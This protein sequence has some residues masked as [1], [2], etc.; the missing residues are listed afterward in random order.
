[1]KIKV[2]FA[3]RKLSMGLISLS[4]VS[5]LSSKYGSYVKADIIKNTITDKNVV[6][7]NI[8]IGRKNSISFYVTGNVNKLVLF[9]EN[10]KE[11]GSDISGT[12]FFIN[13]RSQPK[14]NSQLTVKAYN[15]I[16]EYQG[17]TSFIYTN[18][19]KLYD[20]L[21]SGYLKNTG[22]YINSTKGDQVAY[23]NAYANAIKVTNSWTCSQ[24]E[25]DSATQKY[26]IAR[27]KIQSAKIGTEIKDSSI[28]DNIDV[29]N[30]GVWFLI[31][32][33]GMTVVK[34]FNQGEELDNLESSYQYVLKFNSKLVPN[35]TLTIKAYDL[36]GSQI[37][38]LV[39][40]YTDRNKFKKE[41]SF[42]NLKGT[43]TYKLAKS[44][45]QKAYDNAFN[46]ASKVNS[47][48]NATQSQVDDVTNELNKARLD[49][50]NDT[51]DSN[52]NLEINSI[53]NISFE[54]NRIF[55]TANRNR[56]ITITD[57]E[58]NEPGSDKSGFQFYVILNKIIRPDTPLY[59]N[60]LDELKNRIQRIK[61]I[62]TDRTEFHKAYYLGN[63]KN[64][65][66]YKN[67]TKR[68]QQ[69]YDEAY[70][71]AKRLEKNYV[72]SQELVDNVTKELRN[73]FKGL[74][75]NCE[76]NSNNSDTNL[77]INNI[78]LYMLPSDKSNKLSESKEVHISKVVYA[79]VISNKRNIKI[80]LVNAEG[81]VTNKFINTDS[82]WKVFAQKEINGHL[83]YRLGTQNQ[84]ALADYFVNN[85]EEKMSG[86]ARINYVP[87]YG[88]NL[89][90]NYGKDAKWNGTR[91]KHGT[92]WKIFK[93]VNVNGKTWYNLGGNQWILGK[94]VVLE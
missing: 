22:K 29:S 43:Q 26:I 88:I 63:L 6:F 47:N 70:A 56:Y 76:N 31:P 33:K 4:I 46:K 37:G 52:K 89:W 71:D 62:Y 93:R 64:T 45:L 21:E 35:T 78:P 7:E 68:A 65:Y 2:G 60:S 17:K 40:N 5:T 44:N 82:K 32:K 61:V 72:A 91:L 59:I 27:N 86:I 50:I 12:Q 9:D 90:N 77:F 67:A 16:G 15:N 18:R 92:R 34:L 54:D 28:F 69:K 39:F 14:L 73:A 30:D 87:W 3:L 13:L 83:Y 81:K 74:A 38:E 23:D 51:E 57:M 41:Y 1:M 48:Y 94:Y 84:W 10:G 8:K 80:A 66:R 24:T 53:E 85:S 55:V 19:D 42:Y 11:I 75:A 36:S 49:L 25:V 58:G 20:A 79:P